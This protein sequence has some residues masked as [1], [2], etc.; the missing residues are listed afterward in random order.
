PVDLRPGLSARAEIVTDRRE[1]ALAVPI[2]ALTIRDPAEE[3]EKA[4]GKKRTSRRRTRDDE[5][6]QEVEGVFRIEDDR[7]VFVEC[8]TGIAAEKDFEV[9]DGLSDG[10][11][12]VSGPF[13]AIRNLSSGDQVKAKGGDR[14]SRRDRASDEDGDEE[15]E[16]AAEGDAIADEGAAAGDADGV[17]EAGAAEG[18]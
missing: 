17:E 7:A 11:R 8:K 15:D 13:E 4:A 2:A 1:D 9:T 14:S 5:D 12:I 3:A 18:A 16:A 10:D 6:V